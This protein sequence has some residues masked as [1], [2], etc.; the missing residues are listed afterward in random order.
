M[1]D[2]TNTHLLQCNEYKPDSFGNVAYY[3]LRAVPKGTGKLET[4]ALKPS[5]LISSTKFKAVLL[6]Y[7]ILYIAS[8]VEHNK[9]LTRLFEVSPREV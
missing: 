9:N 3:L 4:I 2:V 6:N 5:D 8:Q 1:L 7:C